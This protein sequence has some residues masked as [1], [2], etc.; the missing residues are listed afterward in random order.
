MKNYQ[1]LLTI[2][3]LSPLF[4]VMAQEFLPLYEKN[5]P[6]YIE[7]ANEQTSQVTSGILRISKVS[8]PTYA[9]YASHVNSE[10][11][12][13]PVVVICP[14]GGYGI[15]AAQHEG[16]DVAKKFN[17]IGIHALVLYYRIPNSSNQIDKK[18]A[19]LQDAQQAI[20]LV[21]KNAPNWGIDTSKVGIMGF[22]AGGHLASTAATHFDKDYTGINDGINLRPDFQ[23]LLYPVISFREFTHSGSRNNLIGANPSEE[24]LNLF[25]NEEQITNKTPQAFLVHASDDKAVPLKNSLIYAENLVKNNVKVDLHVFANGGHGFGLNNKSTKDDWF[26]SLIYWFKSQSI[27]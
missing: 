1:I 13:K 17:E 8:K 14:G 19:P 15:L 11:K 22:S 23:I 12:H 4:N 16:D 3:F 10:I 9:F 27:L 21:R 6:N 2:L 5:I 7:S 18:I 20:R 25:S 26:Q 24:L